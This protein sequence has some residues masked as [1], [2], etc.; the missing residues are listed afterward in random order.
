M[1]PHYR[2]RT[3]IRL[4]RYL[5]SAAD[6]IPFAIERIAF[7]DDLSSLR[8]APVEIT[9]GFIFGAELAVFGIQSLPV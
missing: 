1:R 3:P 2:I 8:Q 5:G 6:A 7:C 9:P 4:Q